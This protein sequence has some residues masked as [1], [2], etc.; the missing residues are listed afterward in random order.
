MVL[1]AAATV[2]L[3]VRTWRTYTV[4]TSAYDAGVPATSSVRAWMTLRYVATTY[5][6]SED[7]LREQLGL[8]AH[9]HPDA[10]LKSL[11]ELAGVP[12]RDYVQRVQRAIAAAAP[13]LAAAHDGESK[14]WISGTGDDVVSAVLVYGYPAL[15]LMLLLGALG[16][17]LPAGLAMVV[18]GSLA[19]RGQMHWTALAAVATVASLAGDLAG[20]AIGRGLGNVFPNRWG[21]W[22]GLTPSRRARAERLFYRWGAASILLSRSLVSALGSA[23]NLVAGAGRYR[24]VAFLGYGLAGRVLWTALYMGLGYFTTGALDPAADFLKHLTGLLVALALVAGSGAALRRSDAGSDS[25]A[26]DSAPPPG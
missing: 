19:A 7:A 14:S 4:L 6:V 2:A 24:L 25:G 16:V 11:A 26:T 22:L 17:S 9:T 20:Y 10:T 21:R 1:V 23:V 15:A 18:A 8:T 12:R 3:G 13:P 5:Q